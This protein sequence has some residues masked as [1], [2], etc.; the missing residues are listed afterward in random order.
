MRLQP[1]SIWCCSCFENLALDGPLEGSSP[2]KSSSPFLRIYYL[3]ASNLNE[4][5]SVFNAGVPLDDSIKSL[6]SFLI[7]YL[8]FPY[9]HSTD[10]RVFSHTSVY[11]ADYSLRL[12]SAVCMQA[13]VYTCRFSLYHS[14]F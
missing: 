3:V 2:G 5:A 9:F 7:I 8:G 13:E 10:E 4:V 14:G 12:N 11:T 6:Q 1:E